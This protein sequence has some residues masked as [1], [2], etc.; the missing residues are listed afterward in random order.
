MNT[1]QFYLP[2]NPAYEYVGV[3][4]K[5]FAITSGASKR[6]FLFTCHVVSCFVVT[7]YD[8]A[9]SIGALAHIDLATPL[10]ESVNKLS[11]NFI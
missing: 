3:P 5:G 7:L 1:T 2:K 11:H 10:T 8:K 4:Q 9:S 6:N